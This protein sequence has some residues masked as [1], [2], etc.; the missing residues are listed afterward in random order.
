MMAAWLSQCNL[1][2]PLGGWPISSWKVRNHARCCPALL[3]PMYSDS[4]DD[5]ATN[6]CSLLNYPIAAWL[7]MNTYPDVDREL[8]V[9]PLQ[10]ASMYPWKSMFRLMSEPSSTS[11]RSLVPLR[12]HSARFANTQWLAFGFVLYCLMTLTI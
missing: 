12:Y 2:A 6:G 4:V 10:F 11:A 5:K 9:S 3:R 8:S 1:V 7:L